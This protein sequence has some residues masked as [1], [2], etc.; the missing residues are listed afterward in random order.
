MNSAVHFLEGRVAHDDQNGVAL[1]EE[2]SYQVEK[3]HYTLLDVSRPILL[4]V[5]DSLLFS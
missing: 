1:A 5:G 2:C 3:L 4:R